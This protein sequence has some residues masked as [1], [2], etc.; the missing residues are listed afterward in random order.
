MWQ[1][2]RGDLRRPGTLSIS[3]TDCLRASEMILATIHCVKRHCTYLTQCCRIASVNARCGRIGLHV[4]LVLCSL[5]IHCNCASELI[6]IA[7]LTSLT[8]AHTCLTAI[9]VAKN[10]VIV[11][12]R[13]ASVARVPRRRV[14]Q[15]VLPV[16]MQEMSIRRSCSQATSSCS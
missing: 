6:A 9:D 1:R 8:I 16:N 3:S 14:L 10:A 4:R 13:I 11:V 7:M 12:I 15:F 5:V 2:N